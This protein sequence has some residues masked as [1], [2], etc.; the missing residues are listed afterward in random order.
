[1]MIQTRILDLPVGVSS[2]VLVDD[3]V[4]TI[5]LNARLSAEDRARHYRHELGHIQ[6]CDFEKEM[7]ADEIEYYA[8]GGTP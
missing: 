6:N 5:V 7:T 4:Y 3:G 2:F 8:H 1:M